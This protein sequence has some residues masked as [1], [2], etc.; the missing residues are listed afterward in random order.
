MMNDAIQETTIDPTVTSL[1]TPNFTVQRK[2]IDKAVYAR[3]RMYESTQNPVYALLRRRGE[4]IVWA[5]LWG[6]IACFGRFTG[7]FLLIVVVNCKVIWTQFHAYA[8]SPRSF[9][10]LSKTILRIYSVGTCDLWRKSHQLHHKYTNVKGK[11]VDIPIYESLK[12]SKIAV[13]II[14]YLVIKECS[15]LCSVSDVV[16]IVV[17]FTLRSILIGGLM[18]PVESLVGF[19]INS[20]YIGVTFG[21]SH[22]IETEYSATSE[23]PFMN[24]CNITSTWLP[25]IVLDEIFGGI[26][27]HIEHHMYPT[28]EWRDLK[29]IQPILRRFA[30][31]HGYP[32]REIEWFDFF[33]HIDSCQKVAG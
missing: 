22:M 21:L 31:E 19:F 24:T 17:F 30:N 25:R 10:G 29:A 4:L 15:T 7:S 1:V 2:E 13:L 23:H 12:R 33:R 5:L 6:Y 11:D 8:H 26:N 3:V 32:Y 20:C 16:Q 18:T 28:L 9:G 14:P 27:Y